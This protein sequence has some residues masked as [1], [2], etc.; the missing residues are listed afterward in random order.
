MKKHPENTTDDSKAELKTGLKY[1]PNSRGGLG[2]G[3]ER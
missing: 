2:A 1:S 3:G